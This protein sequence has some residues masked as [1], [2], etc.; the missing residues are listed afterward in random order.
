MFGTRKQKTIK[1]LAAKIHKE[2]F[3]HPA[4]A[5]KFFPNYYKEL[6]PRKKGELTDG[7]A[8]ACVPFLE[9]CSS[10]YIIPMWADMYVY[11][12]NGEISLKF[13]DNLPME[14]SLAHH[15]IEQLKGYPNENAPYGSTIIKFI[16]PWV[17]ETAPGYSCIFTSPLNHFE[18]RFKIIDAV[19]DT[20]TYYNNVNFP[21]VWT[22]GDGEFVVKQGTPIVQIIPFKREDHKLKIDL[23]DEE[24]K[25][26]LSSKLS[27]KIYD[28]YKQLFWHKRKSNDGI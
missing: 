20:D 22:G 25:R 6:A 18:N 23:I 15:N 2:I 13:A 21:F 27:T 12:R 3:P 9:A 7:T 5:N 26:I 1:F 28:S 16:N 24:K 10:G 8:K 14:E 11:T 17:I 19:V 4:K